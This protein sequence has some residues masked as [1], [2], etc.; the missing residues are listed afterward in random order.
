M[1]TK[2]VAVFDGAKLLQTYPITLDVVGGR[3]TDRDFIAEAKEHA[4]EDKLMPANKL[5]TLKFV[6]RPS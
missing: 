3:V 5:S 4:A 2:N 1:P 6:V